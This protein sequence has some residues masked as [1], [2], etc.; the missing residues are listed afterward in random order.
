MDFYAKSYAQLDSV[1]LFVRKVLITKEPSPDFLP[2]WLNWIKVIV[3]ADDL[4]LNVGRDSLQVTKSLRQIQNI[5]LKKAVDHVASVAKKD[6]VKYAALWKK[7][8]TTLK[9]GAVEDNKYRDKLA[10]L[11]RFQTS[12][13]SNADDLVGLEDY[14]SR[15]KKNQ[16]Q[17]YYIAGAGVTVE[18]L[19]RSPFVEKLVARGYEVLYLTEP[20]DEMIT[21][22]LA[23]FDGLKFQDVAKKGLEMGDENEDEEEKTSLEEFKK[24]YEPLSKWIKKVL[25]EF[26]ADGQSDFFFDDIRFVFGLVTKWLTKEV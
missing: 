14:V 19:K 16:K 6:P 12:Q 4:P 21:S 1:R 10:K 17:I 13:S 7:M 2:K 18:Q 15:R 22:S 23:T 24:Q 3:D 25:N 11:L 26:V 8:G 20:M 9:V 5:I